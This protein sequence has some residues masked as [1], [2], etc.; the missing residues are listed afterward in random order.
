M[1][2]ALIKNK[3]IL[4]FTD[5]IPKKYVPWEYKEVENLEAGTMDVVT[6]KEPVD[7]V[8]YDLAIELKDPYNPT[9]KTYSFDEVNET[10]IERWKDWKDPN[11][12]PQELTPRQVRL[13]MLGAGLDL[14][15]I[16]TMIAG[17]D[18]P[19]K[20][21]VKI[22]WEYSTVF[23]RKDPILNGFAEQLGLSQEDV[24]NLFI[25]GASIW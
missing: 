10:I 19:Q 11:A 25:A 8:D 4:Y 15:Q 13:A 22:M 18:E 7:G 2:I 21:Q 20:S 3:E 6:I 24:D 23:L 5:Q 12:I 14:S 17:L 1:K 9:E 16:D